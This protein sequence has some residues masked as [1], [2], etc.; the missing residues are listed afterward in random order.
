MFNPN[1]DKANVAMMNSVKAFVIGSPGEVNKKFLAYLQD[2][3]DK[4]KIKYLQELLHKNILAH[5]TSGFE[6]SL[7]EVLNDKGVQE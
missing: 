3:A 5:C 4:K 2:S 1:H 7:K 6:H